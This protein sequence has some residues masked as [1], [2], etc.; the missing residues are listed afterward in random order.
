MSGMRRSKFYIH[1]FL[2]KHLFSDT[3]RFILC[4]FIG[5]I[6]TTINDGPG[7]LMLKCPDPS[8]PAAIGRDMIDKLAC[9]EDKEK[10]YRYF[11]RSYVEDNRK[12][13]LPR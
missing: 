9:K 2:L 11:L 12:V 6:S 3:F 10:Y 13:R 1:F 7:C 4:T 5:Y 8:C